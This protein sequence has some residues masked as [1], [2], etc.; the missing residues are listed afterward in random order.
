METPANPF[1]LS[2]FSQEKHVYMGLFD[3]EKW[4]ESIQPH[5]FA[6]SF[7][8]LTKNEGMNGKKEIICIR[9]NTRRRKSNI[10]FCFLVQYA[11]SST[12]VKQIIIK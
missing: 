1:T 4:Y 5:T 12:T 3:V 10:F 6:T 9:T 7:I 2:S 11:N 8:P